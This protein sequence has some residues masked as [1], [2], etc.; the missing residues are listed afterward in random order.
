MLR[1]R[2]L[3]PRMP[4]RGFATPDHY[5]PTDSRDLAS[6]PDPEK[7][8]MAEALQSDARSSG[9]KLFPPGDVR[10]GIVHVVGP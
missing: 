2:G 3:V 10:Q 1:Q 7:R 6:M 9:I 8:A 4:S 5:V